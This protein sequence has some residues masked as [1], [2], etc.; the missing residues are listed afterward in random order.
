MIEVIKFGA[1]WCGPC[2]MVAPMIENLKKKY[3]VDGSDTQITS[4]DIDSSP[5][6]AKEHKIMSIPAFVFMKDG[7]LV[8]KKIGVMQESE[9]E[10]IINSI[11]NE[12]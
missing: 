7:V 1:D 8:S 4:I 11:K 6:Y 3:N 12:Q 9:I 5:E 2:R 10:K